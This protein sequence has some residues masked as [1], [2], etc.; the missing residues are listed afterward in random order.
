MLRPSLN[1]NRIISILLKDS[2]SN[3]E[4]DFLLRFLSQFEDFNKLTTKISKTEKFQLAKSLSCKIFSTGEKVFSKGDPVQNFYIVLKGTVEHISTEKGLKTVTLCS[5]GKQIGDKSY[6]RLGFRNSFCVSTTDSLL[7][8]ISMDL[9][10]ELLGEDAH[11][12]LH[13][14]LKFV[15]LYFPGIK[16]YSFSHRER[17]A[18]NFE[19]VVAKKGQ[20]IH[21]QG[22]LSEKVFFLC[23]GEVELA[24]DQSKVPILKISPGSCIGE[25]V[26]LG[27]E[28]EYNAIVSSEQAILYSMQKNDVAQY[29]PEETKEAWKRNYLLKE[30]ERK[31]L[32]FNVEMRLSYSARSVKRPEF[33]MASPQAKKH[34]NFVSQRYTISSSHRDLREASHFLDSKRI[35]M[36][37]RDSARVKRPVTVKP[38]NFEF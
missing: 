13:K 6:M 3:E 37:L 27:Q 38:A 26:L 1:Y 18:H 16:K 29:V 8:D 23:E 20:I 36:Q 9:F 5:A 7:L 14:K 28:C 15:D 32:V 34:L 35:L 22:E 17:I 4:V 10:R 21:R 11:M 2:K 31:R 25:E 33:T 24:S 12:L 30:Q 19:V